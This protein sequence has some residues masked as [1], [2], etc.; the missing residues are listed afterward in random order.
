MINCKIQVAMILMHTT[1]TLNQVAVLIKICSFIGKCLVLISTNRK[2]RWIT[3]NVLVLTC[4][5]NG[6]SRVP[7]CYQAVDNPLFSQLSDRIIQ[8]DGYF[9]PAFIRPIVGK[10]LSFIS[11]PTTYQCKYHYFWIQ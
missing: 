3:H 10:V 8:Q 9:N 7:V 2:S 4:D 5:S 11:Q 6:R 1:V